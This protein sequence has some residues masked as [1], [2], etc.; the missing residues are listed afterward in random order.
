[1]LAILR[2]NLGLGFLI[3]RYRG[4][5]KMSIDAKTKNI[6]AALDNSTWAQAEAGLTKLHADQNFLDLEA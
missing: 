4:L 3:D 1:M 6:K 2:Q 5:D